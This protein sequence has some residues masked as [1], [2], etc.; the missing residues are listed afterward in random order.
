MT[1]CPS[2]T[3][4]AASGN[5]ALTSSMAAMSGR[6]NPWS[7]FW[8]LTH[9]TTLVGGTCHMTDAQVCV[10]CAGSEPTAALC[11]RVAQDI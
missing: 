10:R 2:T 3:L 9:T 1:C 6:S 8:F 11:F 7:C 5:R 4:M